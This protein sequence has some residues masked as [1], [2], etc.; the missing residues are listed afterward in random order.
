MHILVGIPL[1]ILMWAVVCALIGLFVMLGW[2]GGLS[3]VFEAIP[4]IGF[5][6]AF[7]LAVLARALIQPPEVNVSTKKE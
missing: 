2:N 1:V 4:D 3:S 7:W 6:Q 5:W